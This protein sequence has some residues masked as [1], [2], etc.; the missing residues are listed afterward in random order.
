L[1]P[2]KD[3]QHD[4]DFLKLSS[5]EFKFK[6]NFLLGKIQDEKGS[7][8]FPTIEIFLYFVRSFKVRISNFLPT[9]LYNNECQRVLPLKE[10]FC[11][12]RY[13]KT[14]LVAT[15]LV[16]LMVTPAMVSATPIAA[17]SWVPQKVTGWTLA[18]NDT[19]SDAFGIYGANLT[20]GDQNVIVSNWTQLWYENTSASVITGIVAT[21][22]YQYTQDFFS[23]TVNQTV[24]NAVN[25][26]ASTIGSTFTGTTLW[27][28]MFWLINATIGKNVPV[29][30]VTKNVTGAMGAMSINMTTE[31]SG[32]YLL[33]AYSGA[34]SMM[35]LSLDVDPNWATWIANSN[36]TAM[37][38]YVLPTVEGIATG[39]SIFL[40]A[41]AALGTGLTTTASL[42]PVVASVPNAASMPNVA[43]SSN[44]QT[45]FADLQA[46]ASAFVSQVAGPSIPGFP[47]YVIGGFAIIGIALV[48]RKRKIAVP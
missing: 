44:S 32:V 41:F 20:F 12:M 18:Y 1:N 46:F 26:Y 39:L 4:T 13:K 28:L 10:E 42:T 22:S 37:N 43:A 35:I 31:F 8:L 7:R 14:I 15:C 21:V 38:Q 29:A 33:Y 34:Y 45:S 48:V 27:D 16:A 47:V 3:S 17:P 24:K 19:I 9:Y 36:T 6:R 11:L 25:S 2:Q 23:Q 5:F 40:L 30:D